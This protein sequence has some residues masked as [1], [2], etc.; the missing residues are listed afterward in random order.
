ML[1]WTGEGFLPW[2]K[3]AAIAYE[4]LHRYMFSAQ[5]VRGKRVLVRPD[6]E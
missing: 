4:H 1:E 5:F 2:V 6:R 3:E